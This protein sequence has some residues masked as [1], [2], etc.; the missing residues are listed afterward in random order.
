[1]NTKS[2]SSCEPASVHLRAATAADIAVMIA[3][4][5]K[6]PLAA[7]WSEQTY[8]EILA[9]EAPPRI[10][11]VAEDHDTI[12]GFLIARLTDHDC[13]LE[14]IVVTPGLQRR[15]TGSELLRALI[16]GARARGVSR[17]ILEVRESN[18]AARAL[19]E[20]FGFAITGRRK[21]YYG[22]SVE[23][24]DAVLYALQL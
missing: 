2:G 22:S 18:N 7:H 12:I 4:E 16:S 15:G 1:M 5:R 21:S 23:L 11:I 20:Q 19:Y 13:E 9:P 10:F 8:L 3:L 14:N 24:E 6:V 17:I